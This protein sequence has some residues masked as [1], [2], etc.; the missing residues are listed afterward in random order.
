[1]NPVTNVSGGTAAQVSGLFEDDHRPARS[2][3][4]RG[5]R[6]TGQTAS[7]HDHVRVT[8]NGSYCPSP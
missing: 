4:Q 1:M 3:D 2:R 7:D 8:K 5:R 6:E